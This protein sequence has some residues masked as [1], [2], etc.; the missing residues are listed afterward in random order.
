M[1]EPRI[2]LLVATEVERQ[3]VLK[4]LRAPKGRK[5]VLQV[6]V[7][8]NT[9][10]VGR[11]GA[12]DAVLCM[13]SMGSTGRDSSTTVTGEFI[14]HWQLKAVVMVGIAFG[15]DAEKQMIGNVLVS[16]RIIQYEP[17]R[18]SEELN[19]NRGSEPL[20][21]TTLLNRFR[22][23][24]GWRFTAPNGDQCGFQTG[25]IL[26]GWALSNNGRYFSPF[27]SRFPTNSNVHRFA[28]S[29]LYSPIPWTSPSHPET[30]F[31]SHCY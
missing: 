19:V 15:K 24:L 7:D 29:P 23:V 9:C 25:P 28:S 6:F 30:K 1:I 10:F 16:D 27:N 22:N 5:A 17:Q 26:S 14:D 31:D 21:G 8:S 18:V 4:R 2:G 20:A 11:F 13:T 3:A 12:N